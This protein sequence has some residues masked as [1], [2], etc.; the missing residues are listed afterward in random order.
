VGE[1]L[2]DLVG[3]DVEGGGELDVADVVTAEVHVHEA[4][5]ELIVRRVLVVLAALQQ[6]VRAVADTDDG[7]AN[8]VI[9][10]WFAVLGFPVRFSHPSNL[11]S[12]ACYGQT[13]A[14]MRWCKGCVS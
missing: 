10:P 5:D 4:G 13:I 9:E 12:Q 7:G 1:I 14:N 6:R 8:A 2:A 11:L 3:R